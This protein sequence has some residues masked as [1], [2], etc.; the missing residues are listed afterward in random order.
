M[1]RKIRKVAVLGAGVMGSGIAAHLANVGVPC[2][3]LDIVPPFLT[4]EQ[5]QDKKKR[6]MFAA[7]ALKNTVKS[8]PALFYRSDL[9][10]FVT[11]G[12]L[13]DLHLVS[14]CDWIIEVVKEDM[15]IKQALFKRLLEYRKPGSVVS[16]NTSGLSI[17][18]M[19]EGL[20]EE[21]KKHFLVTHFFNPVR[22]M[23]L[24]ELVVGPETDPAVTQFIADFGENVLGKGIVYGKDTPNFVANRIG[25]HAVM[26]TLKIMEELDM[27]PEEVDVIAGPPMG[28]PRTA[29]FRTIDLVGL[30]TF[31]AVSM[32]VYNNCPNDEVRDLFNVPGYVT[33]MLEKKY[34]GNKTKGGFYQKSK[35]EDGKK[36][37]MA[38][39]LKTLE[40]EPVKKPKFPSVDKTK[41]EEDL[42]K[43]LRILISGDDKASQ[44]AWK[45]LVASFT[46][47]SN[48]MGEIADD[49][50]NIDRGMRWG[51]N[52]EMG[53]FEVWD[54]V[55]VAATAERMKK[56]GIPVPALAIQVLEKGEGTFYKNVGGEEFYFDVKTNRYLP[57]PKRPT[58]LTLKTCREKGSAL[59]TNESATLHDL[60]DGCLGLEFH[61]KMNSIDDGI[62]ETMYRANEMLD[63]GWEGLVIY[64]EG[65]N[66]SVG[67]NLMLIAM[68]AAQKKYDAIEMIVDRFQKI[69]DLNHRA[70]KPVVAVPHT[71]VLG[72][73]CEVCLGASHIVAA[74]E[75]YIGLVEVGVGLIPGGGGT[76]EML[77]RWW[78]LMSEE[79]PTISN[80]PYLQKV[81]ELIGMAKVATSAREAEAYRIL[82]PGIDK[83]VVSRD[84]ILHVAREYALGLSRADY[85]AVPEKKLKVAGRDGLALVEAGLYSFG[86]S[87]WVSEYDKFIGRKLGYVLCG[88]DVAPGTLVSESRILEL[89]KQV[90]MSLLGEQKTMDR[91]RY[92]LQNN[93]PLRN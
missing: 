80:L 65:Q 66:F 43:K 19:T 51:F 71:L 46:Y 28:R 76:K 40:Y 50:V 26:A 44:F 9:A 78:D 59:S 82:R 49:V 62:V 61:S 54:A 27:T 77:V 53:P 47:V 48:R 13:E 32:N 74:A 24:L 57:V 87:G 7:D 89:E 11:T 22:Y 67:A 79:L 41:G 23:K 86:L 31:A 92:M 58:W 1:K 83:V 3:M 6:D 73:G 36:Q 4:E 14:D 35:G 88:G 60:G 34:L 85:R 38:L 63:E 2:V 55:G 45:G 12:N 84:N 42:A 56:E 37:V 16:S 20:P 93:K 8:K 75:T 68:Y 29:A 64:N 10:A 72:G 90:F 91:I 33:G 5:K 18:G 39:N 70:S 15:G 52:W 21:F 17:D 25:V 81:F 69:N 30:D